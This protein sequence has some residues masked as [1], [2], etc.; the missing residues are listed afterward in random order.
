MDRSLTITTA[1]VEQVGT[2]VEWAAAEG[3]N[4]GL[5]DA[6]VFH[7]ADPGGF[8]IGSVGEEPVSAV[9]LVQYGPR[10]AFLGLYLV[11]PE[12]RGRGHGLAVWQAA[13]ERA[14]TRTIGLDGVVEHQ[15]DYRRSGFVLAR[16]NVRFGGV[17]GADAPDGLLPLGAVNRSQVVDFDAGVFPVRRQRFLRAWLTM[18]GA[19]GVAAVADGELSGYGVARPC[20]S[21]VKVGPLFA[22]DETTAEAIFRGL[23]SWA[24][25]Q[26][27]FLDVPEPNAAATR[28]AERH[29]LT[30]VFETARMYAGSAPSEPVHRIYGVT[31]FELG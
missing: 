14:G 15:A 9:S 23:S 13:V 20:L 29:G 4:P 5:S 1:E 26:P 6:A 21:G 25:N 7:A 18:P 11:R 10:F 3:W 22:D 12:W 27:I 16:R 31:T 24:G 19:Y 8:L 28:L 17:G 30:P 2:I